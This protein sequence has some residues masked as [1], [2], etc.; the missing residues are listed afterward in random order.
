MI[1]RVGFELVKLN[2]IPFQKLVNGRGPD[3]IS[4]CILIVSSTAIAGKNQAFLLA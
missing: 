3:S 4:V 2:H 1:I